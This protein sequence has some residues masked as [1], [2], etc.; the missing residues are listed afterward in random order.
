[1]INA[2]ATSGHVDVV[3]PMKL[4][5]TYP[6]PTTLNPG[7]TFTVSS[8]WEPDRN[9]D[10]PA[11]LKTRSPNAGVSVRDIINLDQAQIEFRVK[12]FSHTIFHDWLAIPSF[13]VDEELFNTDTL[14]EG[15]IPIPKK[16]QS[17]LSC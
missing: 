5:L 15:G 1:K 2:F 8:S 14:F 12:A 4:T 3:Y 7:E 9:A 13:H 17:I 11:S 16:L 6:D 10:K